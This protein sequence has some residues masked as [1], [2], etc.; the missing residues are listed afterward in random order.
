M[1]IVDAERPGPG[2]VFR[3]SCRVGSTMEVRRFA[4]REE[5]ARHVVDEGILGDPE[6]SEVS[7][8][9]L[10]PGPDVWPL[11][12]YEQGWASGSSSASQYLRDNPEEIPAHEAALSELDQLRS[13]R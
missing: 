12:G 10:P 9:V 3:V 1:K 13:T 11:P 7:I 4:T 2:A 5:M 8:Q 6:I